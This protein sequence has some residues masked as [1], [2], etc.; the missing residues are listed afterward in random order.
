MLTSNARLWYEKKE[1]CQKLQPSKVFQSA[2][3]GIAIFSPVGR[4]TD[5]L[6]L[7]AEPDRHRHRGTWGKQSCRS[8]AL[9][10][11]RCRGK[12]STLYHPHQNPYRYRRCKGPMHQEWH[13][14]C[15]SNLC[16]HNRGTIADYSVSLTRFWSCRLTS[17]LRPLCYL[18]INPAFHCR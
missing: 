18:G 1:G 12:H 5:P 9:R 17:C 2:P 7:T 11:D 3:D 4:R 15:P 10:F 14:D 6:S 13:N 8:Y 16:P